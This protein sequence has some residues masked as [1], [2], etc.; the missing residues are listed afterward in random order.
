MVTPINPFTEVQNTVD[1]D[2][3]Q[4]LLHLFYF[5]EQ[6]NGTTG[7]DAYL[8]TVDVNV[9]DIDGYVTDEEG[10]T[11][12]L[13]DY[14]KLSPDVFLVGDGE[15]HPNMKFGGEWK[16]LS[17][18]DSVSHAL[19]YC[20]VFNDDESLVQVY[21]GIQGGLTIDLDAKIA[22]YFP[23]TSTHGFMVYLR[24]PNETVML[25]RGGILLTPGTENFLSL[26]K[27]EVTRLEPRYGD[28]QNVSSNFVP[29]ISKSV[30]ECIQENVFNIS[31]S[32]CN[33]VPW[34]LI[35]RCSE[36][37]LDSYLTSWY[38]LV[39]NQGSSTQDFQCGF[40][41][42]AYCNVAVLE[43]LKKS[44]NETSC[45][46]PCYFEEWDWD[47]TTTTFPPS[48]A[49]Y[50]AILRDSISKVSDYNSTYAYAQSNFVRLHIY[51]EDIKVTSIAQEKAYEIFNFVAELG[52]TVDLLIGFSFFTIFQLLEIAIAYCCY[53]KCS[54]RKGHDM[55]GELPGG[56][57]KKKERMKKQQV[58]HVRP[59][60]GN[61]MSTVTSFF[62]IK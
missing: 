27:V 59:A 19:G 18:S 3:L 34:Y 41:T 21:G 60:D 16:T 24:N 45:P 48:E 54:R 4:D 22:D 36:L 53:S 31:V 15:T 61:M 11:L 38:T 58:E 10:T 32:E 35:E 46:E 25:D 57:Q 39:E 43:Y 44:A 30:R 6:H 49:Y 7:I 47:L 20:L 28:C 13:F 55:P 33:C 62:S 29:S 52:G 2:T 17:T 37:G 1:E 50:N 23:T 26:D 14:F 56:D 42:Q 9:T 12:N 40:A 8:K 51:Y 5:I